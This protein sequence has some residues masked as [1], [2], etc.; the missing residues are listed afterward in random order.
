MD[1]VDYHNCERVTQ[2]EPIED[3][4]LPRCGR[5]ALT[6]GHG[7]SDGVMIRIGFFD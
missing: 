6:R 3:R 1:G 4:C 5:G 7:Q 2:R